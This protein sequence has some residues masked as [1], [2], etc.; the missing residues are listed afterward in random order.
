MMADQHD[1]QRSEQLK[2]E[3]V[4]RAFDELV[5]GFGE[6]PGTTPWP[7]AEDGDATTER[8]GLSWRL[9]RRTEP[10][11]PAEEEKDDGVDFA[12]FPWADP[13][14]VDDEDDVAVEEE[15]YEP[16]PPPPLPKL[17]PVGKAAWLGLVGGPVFLIGASLLGWELEAWQATAALGAFVGGFAVLVARMKDKPPVDDGWDDGAVV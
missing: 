10:T 4:D 16:P 11:S 13:K 14:P 2:R 3:D 9:A 1:M 17:D 15:R 12:D 8:T 5:A 6:L 7:A